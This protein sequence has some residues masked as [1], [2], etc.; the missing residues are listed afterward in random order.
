MSV[1]SAPFKEEQLAPALMLGH[2]RLQAALTNNK[3]DNMSLNVCF[4]EQ[5]T[6][7]Y[8]SLLP[9]YLAVFCKATNRLCVVLPAAR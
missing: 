8:F 7:F 9:E 1:G 5:I 4:I 3:N 6:A 2:A